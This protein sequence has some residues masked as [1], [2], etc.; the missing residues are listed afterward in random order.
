MRAGVRARRARGL[1]RSS[2]SI[3]CLLQV[4]HIDAINELEKTRNL[5]R[6]QVLLTLFS[7]II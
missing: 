7:E 3:L 2:R 6:V 4:Q 5:L 1:L